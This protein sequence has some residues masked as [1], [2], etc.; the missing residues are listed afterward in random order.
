[1][2]AIEYNNLVFNTMQRLRELNVG[3]DSYASCAE[4]SWRPA[5][6]KT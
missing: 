6:N 3:A 5:T 4:E 1:M 2:S